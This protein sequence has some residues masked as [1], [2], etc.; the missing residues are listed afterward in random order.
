MSIPQD[1]TPALPI[2][3]T[4]REGNVK[5]RGVGQYVCCISTDGQRYPALRAD[6]GATAQPA[7]VH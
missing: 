2:F 1:N 5:S 7:L 6:A 3:L 4:F